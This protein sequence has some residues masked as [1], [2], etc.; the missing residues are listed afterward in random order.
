MSWNVLLLARSQ[1]KVNNFSQQFMHNSFEMSMY[2]M[3]NG[4]EKIKCLRFYF[5]ALSNLSIKIT[6]ILTDWRM[7]KKNAFIERLNMYSS[8]IDLQKSIE[9]QWWK[10]KSFPKSSK[11][12][13]AIGLMY[14][15]EEQV[16]HYFKYI[17]TESSRN[18][19]HIGRRV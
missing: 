5:S 6:Y 2:T 13:N 7:V 9:T 15:R 3:H 8:W 4:L 10:S 19:I 12:D 11:S 18:S 14:S 1:H 17:H 16:Q